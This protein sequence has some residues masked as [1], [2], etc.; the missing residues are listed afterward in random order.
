MSSIL[1]VRKIRKLEFQCL[2]PPH[3]CYDFKMIK[4]H[5]LVFQISRLTLHTALDSNL[6]VKKST[7]SAKNISEQ[8]SGCCNSVQRLQMVAQNL[9]R[10]QR[11]MTCPL[12]TKL[13]SDIS[14]FSPILD[15][16]NS[17]ICTQAYLEVEVESKL[18]WSPSSSSSVQ[19]KDSKPSSTEWE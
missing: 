14:H 11:Q 15:F 8:K 3:Q 9:E 17:V 1:S 5:S 4:T 19:E 13:Q 18:V 7:T 12:N 16:R 10:F 2:C 6:C